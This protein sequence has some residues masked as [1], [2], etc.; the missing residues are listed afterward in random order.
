M[1]ELELVAGKLQKETVI[2][3]LL[4]DGGTRTEF[5]YDRQGYLLSER[6]G[7]STTTYAYDTFNLN[8]KARSRTAAMSAMKYDPEGMRSGICENGVTS[9]FVSAG[10]W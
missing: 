5:E 3:S 7:S 8:A 10:I 4:E 1:R 9:R 2:Q 6:S